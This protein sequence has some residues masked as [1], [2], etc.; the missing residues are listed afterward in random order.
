MRYLEKDSIINSIPYNDIDHSKNL[1]QSN[2]SITLSR[3][4][5]PR[6]S[7][8]QK[9]YIQ[10]VDKPLKPVEKVFNGPKNLTYTN[11]AAANE[12]N[13]LTIPKKKKIIDNQII[14][15]YIF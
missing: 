1:K 14:I 13:Q 11:V 10:P 6:K 7:Y 3:N 4:S 15:I 12:L 9:S 2:N 8:L 5:F